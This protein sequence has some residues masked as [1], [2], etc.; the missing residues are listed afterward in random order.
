MIESVT[1]GQ[2]R[3]GGLMPSQTRQ[4]LEPHTRFVSPGLTQEE[5]R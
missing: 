4:C 2:L 5:G 3:V 1:W